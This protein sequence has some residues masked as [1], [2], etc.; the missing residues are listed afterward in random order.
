MV[1]G[2]CECRVCVCGVVCGVG[3]G[4]RIRWCGCVVPLHFNE[5]LHASFS[6]REILERFS[7]DIARLTMTIQYWRVATAAA[8]GNEKMPNNRL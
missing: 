2:V 5:P 8:A 7:D 1:T 6:Y 3:V 4:S